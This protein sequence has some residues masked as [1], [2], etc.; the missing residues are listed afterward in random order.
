MSSSLAW[1]QVDEVYVPI[2]C[3]ENFHWVLAVIALK[4]RRIRIYDS[5]SRQRNIES[6]TE[7][8]KL[9]KMLPT[10][11]SDSKFY[12]E[13]SRIDWANL[14]AHRDKIT[15]TTQ[16]L[17]EPPFEIEYVQD[18]MQQK[19]DKYLSEGMNVPSDD[20]EVEYHRMR[21]A[22]LLQKYGIQKAK[23]VYVSEN[24]DPPRSKS[25]NIKIPDEN[26]I[27]CIE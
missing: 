7:I 13:I 15:Q 2:N 24:D 4:D 1:Y 5:L 10:Y 23:K 11:L 8:Q 14:E 21:Y 26:E 25:R 12:D 3:N 16:I 18:I 9:A 22:T 20:F 27:V 17:N 6:I 19:C